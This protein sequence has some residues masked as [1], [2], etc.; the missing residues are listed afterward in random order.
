MK[1]DRSLKKLGFKR[2]LVEQAVYTRGAGKA[3]ILLGVYVDD[4]IVTGD[5]PIEI[6]N[7]KQQMT[8]L[9]YLVGVA[10]KFM[11]KPTVLHLKVVK[12]I[13][14]Y[15][16]GTTKLGL[17]YTQEGKQE[18]LTGYSDS[19]LGVDVTGRSTGGMAFYLNDSMIS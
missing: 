11:E 16:K 6:N 4:L 8:D 10:S 19:D 17:V 9:A 2:C 18:M 1:L 14:R 3:T 13:L 12:Q 5:D 15:L 7:F